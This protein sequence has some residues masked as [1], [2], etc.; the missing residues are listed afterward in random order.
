MGTSRT[1]RPGMGVDT[2]LGTVGMAVMADIA[3]G[4]LPTGMAAARTVSLGVSLDECA[5][6]NIAA[7]DYCTVL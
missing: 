7:L 6:H 4:T 1:T 5:S 3:A 2:P